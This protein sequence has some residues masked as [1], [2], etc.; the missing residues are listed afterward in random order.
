MSREA[1]MIYSKQEMCD[2][3]NTWDANSL[4]ELG[5]EI[6]TADVSNVLD[7]PSWPPFSSEPSTGSGQGTGQH[8]TAF[9]CQDGQS[10]ASNNQDQVCC[11]KGSPTTHDPATVDAQTRLDLAVDAP[12][13]KNFSEIFWFNTPFDRAFEDSRVETRLRGHVSNVPFTPIILLFYLFPQRICTSMETYEDLATVVSGFADR[14]LFP[15]AF[16]DCSLAFALVFLA[17]AVGI[18]TLFLYINHRKQDWL[19]HTVRRCVYVAGVAFRYFA[20]VFV[21]GVHA[22]SVGPFYFNES[23]PDRVLVFVGVLCSAQ[24]I[25]V[26]LVLDPH[27]S[28]SLVL[29]HLTPVAIHICARSEFPDASKQSEKYLL[30]LIFSTTVVIMT[31]EYSRRAHFLNHLQGIRRAKTSQPKYKQHHD[32][33]CWV[34]NEIL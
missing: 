13:P 31:I 28:W 24:P 3:F 5:R 23:T 12:T 2:L 16:P 27:W 30:V 15:S 18:T 11:S 33:E 6:W 10:A 4:E 9:A 14:E 8:R 26:K 19:W 25:L 1:E 29:H 7:S 32:R 34:S 22:F 17:I 20:G 21:A